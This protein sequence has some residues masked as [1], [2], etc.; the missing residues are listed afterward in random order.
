MMATIKKGFKFSTIAVSVIIA[1]L[2]ITVIWLSVL[3]VTVRSSSSAATQEVITVE[4]VEKSIS[5]R[6]VE[7]DREILIN[8]SSSLLTE[9]YDLQEKDLDNLIQSID[10][11]DFS[12]LPESFTNKFRFVDQF[13]NPDNQAAAFESIIAL[14]YNIAEMNDGVFEEIGGFSSSVFID[15]EAGTAFVPISVFTGMNT[16]FALEYVVI[17]GEWVFS[18]YSTTQGT[19]IAALASG[20]SLE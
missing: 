9:A 4:K 7:E 6:T 8:L 16:G 19:I 5:D 18:P 13:D 17:D 10:Q 14:A 20:N 11:R 3:L 12:V 15:S 1:I 2:M